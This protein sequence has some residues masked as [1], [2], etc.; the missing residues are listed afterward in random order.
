MKYHCIF[1]FPFFQGAPIV[2]IGSVFYTTVFGTPVTIDC[3][4]IADPQVRYVFWQKNVNGYLTSITHG[5]V[6]TQGISPTI[7]SL[8]IMFPSKSD[9]G[10]YTCFGVNDL[11]QRG[12]I[13]TLLKVS[14]GMHFRHK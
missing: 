7:P 3:F 4:I 1:L 10:E 14:G 13:P 11:G 9:Q 2:N 8:T 5:A 12:S 6:G